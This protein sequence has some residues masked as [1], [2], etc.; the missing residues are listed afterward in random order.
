MAMNAFRSRADR[1]GVN[2]DRVRR[3]GKEWFAEV[4]ASDKAETEATR[5][6][7]QSNASGGDDGWWGDLLFGDSD[8]DCGDAGG[9]D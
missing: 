6:Q 4:R 3:L 9:G 1:I 5:K 7:K 8:G 2:E